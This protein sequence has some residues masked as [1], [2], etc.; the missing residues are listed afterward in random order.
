MRLLVAWSRS[1][2]CAGWSRVPAG[3]VVACACR[4]RGRV[5][6][7]VPAGRALDMRSHIFSLPLPP[8]PLGGRGYI[9]LPSPL[10]HYV[11]Q[12]IH[13]PFEGLCWSGQRILEF[14][15]RNVPLYACCVIHV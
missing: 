15:I 4:S 10:L 5:P 8:P 13:P 2:I 6:G 11:A 14:F 12:C 7:Q 1:W 9:Q 3:R